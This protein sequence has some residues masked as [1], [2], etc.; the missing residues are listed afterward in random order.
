M[1]PFL[2]FS[3]VSGAKFSPALCGSCGKARGR[4][5]RSERYFHPKTTS[6]PLV[7]PGQ[8]AYSGVTLA[9]ARDFIICSIPCVL[10]D[11]MPRM[12]KLSK[13][14]RESPYFQ[15]QIAGICRIHPTHF[16]EMIRGIRP[17]SPEQ[18]VA[19]SKFFTCDPRKIVGWIEEKG[20]ESVAQ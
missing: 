3:L 6:Y 14:V 16:S 17:I 4:F 5:P 20:E 18:I 10:G 11:E 7:S 12:T 19:L 2:P 8:R 1:V 15:Y 9:R 13:L